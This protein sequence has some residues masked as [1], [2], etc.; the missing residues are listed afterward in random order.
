LSLSDHAINLDLLR[1]K[2]HLKIK[3]LD[4]KNYIFDPIRKK[5]YILQPEEFVRQLIIVW[6]IEDQKFSRNLIQ[7]EKLF[8]LNGM[9]RRFDIIVYNRQMQACLM[10][11]CKS[12][13]VV[14]TQ[15]AF[16]QISAYQQ[17]IQAPYLMVSNG[18]ISFIAQ[19]NDASKRFEFYSEIPKWNI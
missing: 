11:E 17:A 9:N 8:V 19:M 7:V 10:V 3:T 12:H 5:Y 18:Q 14:I 2:E 6:L 15:Q 13:D 1:W 16:D 4:Q